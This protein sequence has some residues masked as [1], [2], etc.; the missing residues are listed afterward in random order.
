MGCAEVCHMVI[1]AFQSAGLESGL[2]FDDRY[3]APLQPS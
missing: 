3:G 2:L 1:D